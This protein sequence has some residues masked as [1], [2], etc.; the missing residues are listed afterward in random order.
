MA[1][2][3]PQVTPVSIGNVQL[4]FE[5]ARCTVLGHAVMIELDAFTGPTG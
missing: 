2:M 1:R 3:L 4:F 5:Q